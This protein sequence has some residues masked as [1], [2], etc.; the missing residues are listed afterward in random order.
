M[1]HPPAERRRAPRYTV[2]LPVELESWRGT[3]RDVSAAGVYFE[4]DRPYLPGTPIS[5][6][7]VLEHAG[8]AAPMIVRCHAT[9]VRLEPNGHSFGVAAAITAHSVEPWS[10]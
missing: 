5:F 7:L 4:A 10:P 9:V 2:R 3:T 6:G 8:A 1:S